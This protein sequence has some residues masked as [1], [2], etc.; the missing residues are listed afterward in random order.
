MDVV[1]QVS[2]ILQEKGRQIW[3]IAPAETVYDALQIMASKEVGAL[4][5]MEG[6]RLVGILSERDYARKIILKGRSSK[7]TKVNE[8]M[9]SPP[10]TVPSD[11]SVERAM[12]LMTESRVRHLPVT[13]PN[14]DIVGLVSIGD[15][16]KW[17]ITSQQETIQQLHSY[18]SGGSG[19]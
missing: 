3:T 11:C 9:V 4:L 6:E 7:E 16:V 10:L 18:I 17:I 19:A 2:A 8:I 5:V 14:G 13:S 15:L 1:D 12:R